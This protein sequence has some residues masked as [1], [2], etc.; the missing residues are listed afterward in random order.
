[1]LE[2]TTITGDQISKAMLANSISEKE[3]NRRTGYPIAKI[4][5]L[6]NEGAKGSDAKTLMRLL[7]I[8]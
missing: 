8:E 7:K 2:I 4:R 1:M 5:K 3:I 6:I